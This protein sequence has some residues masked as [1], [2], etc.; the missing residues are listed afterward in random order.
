EQ[1]I[2]RRDRGVLLGSGFVGGEGL[3]GVAIAGVAFVQNKK[4]DG[5]GTDWL[6][7]DWMVQ[8]GGLIGFGLLLTWFVRR[9]RG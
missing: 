9:V 2:E 3:L 7:P 4:P 6:G 5:F 1:E 8:I